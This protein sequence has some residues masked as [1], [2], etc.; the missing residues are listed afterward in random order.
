MKEVAIVT[1]STAVITDDLFNEYPYLYTLPLQII[2]KED[3]FYDGS[4]TQDEFFKLVDNYPNLPTTSQPLV[5]DTQELFEKLLKEYKHIIY[6]TISSN[7]SGTY[8][9]SATTAKDLDPDRIKVF[10]SLLTATVLKRMVVEA[11]S[12]VR[13]N[14]DLESILS[15]LKDMR[16]N[17]QA[18]LV[19][20]DLKYL[21][22]TGRING[23]TASIGTILK[24]KP[25]VRFDN[26]AIVMDTKVR[27]MKKAMV[28]L[29][30][31]L[32]ELEVKDNTHILI[33]HAD[34]LEY[35][36]EM[37]ELIEERYPSF[38]TS[39]SELSPVVSVHTGPQSLGVTWVNGY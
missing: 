13:E 8:Q 28:Y 32:S 34:G 20:D 9:T 26:G 2:F 37:K 3:V 21:N 10:D 33:A 17:H 35:A 6:I 12:Y 19:V 16:N 29:L 7:I 4:L 27:T 22:R 24:I 31:K 5:G 14:K 23:A 30:D 15:T 18:F 38:T 39:I 11:C 25:V 36:K 1:D